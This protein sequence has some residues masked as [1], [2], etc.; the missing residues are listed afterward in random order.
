MDT[1]DRTAAKVTQAAAQLQVAVARAVALVD[2]DD[3]ITSEHARDILNA[4]QQVAYALGDV[5]EYTLRRRFA[6][7]DL[8]KAVELIAKSPE[9]AEISVHQVRL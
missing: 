4:C 6:G 7:L 3:A 1:R 2:A 5:I 9:G 8:S